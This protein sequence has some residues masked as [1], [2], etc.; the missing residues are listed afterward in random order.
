MHLHHVNIRTTDL[1]ASIAFYR[2][3]LG[4]RHG[5]RPDF[6]FPGAWLYDRDKPAV[7]LNEAVETP[8]RQSNAFDHVAF[9]TEDLDR[10]LA[11]LDAMGVHYYGLRPLPDGKTRQCFL[12]D[13]NGITIE[14]QGP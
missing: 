12:K 4:L 11:R 7:H 14:L 2:D 8:S 3:A 6:G 13:P 5:D 10:V 9:Y 1:E